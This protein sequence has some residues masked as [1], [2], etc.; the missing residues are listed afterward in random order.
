MHAALGGHAGVVQLFG[1]NLQ[2][3]EC[4][5]VMERCRSRRVSLRVSLRV[6][7]WLGLGLG[8]C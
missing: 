1:A 5:I 7:P 4:C 6:C 3:P 8:L 2:P